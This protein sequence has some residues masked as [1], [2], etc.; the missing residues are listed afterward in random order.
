MLPIIILVVVIGLFWLARKGKRHN[1]ATAAAAQQHKI[2][3]AKAFVERIKD[4]NEFEPVSTRKVLQKPG[5]PVLLASDATLLELTTTTTRGHVGTRVMVGGFPIYLGKSLPMSKTDLKEAAAGELAVT[6]KALLFSGDMKNQTTPVA[7]ITAIETLADGIK[8]NAENRT[9]PL[10]YK[11]ENP[12]LWAL[13]LQIVT[14]THVDGR[15][16]TTPVRVE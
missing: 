7:K 13:V 14:Q 16:L 1:K 5:Q 10:F 4:S 11:V 9:K 12:Y 6:C 2:D 15:T 3:Q 8:V